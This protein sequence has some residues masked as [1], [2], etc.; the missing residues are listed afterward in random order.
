MF[1]A[2]HPVEVHIR[3]PKVHGIELLWVR[4]QLLLE[5]LLDKLAPLGPSA[6]TLRYYVVRE[7][8]KFAIRHLHLV[9]LSV[10]N[11][12][13]LDLLYARR[14]QFI[15]SNTQLA[16]REII[17]QRFLNG[18]AALLRDAAIEDLQL[19]YCVV[20]RQQISNS[21]CTLVFKFAIS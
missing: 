7:S 17:F 13:L 3:D 20:P 6:Q 1:A 2:C 11:H 4:A 18:I 5:L 16:Y 12:R 8:L 10:E 9:V 19:L 14:F 21:Y 15:V